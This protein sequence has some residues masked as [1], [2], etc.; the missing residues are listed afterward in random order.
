VGKVIE[1]DDNN[2]KHDYKVTGVVD[3]SLG[4]SHLHA[5]MFITMNSGGMGEFVRQNDS[6][7]GNNLT[8]SY[9]KLRPHADAAALEKKL[10]AFLN[11][12]GGQQLKDIGMEKI[13]H[14]QPL[15]SI[16]TTTGYEHELSKSVD[17]S[18]LY[19]L[20]LIAVLIQ[21]IACINF[22]NLSTA[23]A[24]KRAK[25]VGVR[26]V[27]GAERSDLMKQFMSESFLLSLISVLIALPLLLLTL[28]LLNQITQADI[29][30]S[31]FAN[32]R[33]WLLLGGIIGATGLVAGS[34]PA[35]YLSGI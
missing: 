30:V 33:V 27:V 6:W 7:A 11:K 35:F 23:R 1:I 14:L 21:V 5:N 24:S 4:K 31:M 29:R 3:E 12:Y 9:I 22:M 28:P 19:I 2:G 16:H 15:S 17:P 25:E 34:Y 8:F 20:L 18:F 26:K 13:L 32:Y 10:P